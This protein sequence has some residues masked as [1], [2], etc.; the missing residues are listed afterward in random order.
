MSEHG[1][2]VTYLAGELA[3]AA[4][5][6]A[7][8]FSYLPAIATL[9]AIVWYAILIIESRTGAAWLARMRIRHEAT[10]A[11]SVVSTEAHIAKAEI[12]EQALIATETIKEQATI[13]AQTLRDT[14]PGGTP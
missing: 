7:A 3:S 1:Y 14:L 9:M 11:K 2:Y 12:K 13:A 10:I 4:A 5:I 6:V 8:F